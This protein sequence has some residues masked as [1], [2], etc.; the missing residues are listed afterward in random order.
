MM[1]LGRGWRA[2]FYFA[3]IIA[4]P[5]FEVAFA[6]NGHQIAW[7]SEATAMGIVMLIGIFDCWR[8]AWF[9]R[10]DFSARWYSGWPG[11]F[12]VAASVVV[13]YVGLRGF[14]FA[15]YRLPSEA[16]LPGLHVNDLILVRKWQYGLRMPF[17]HTLL[18]KLGSPERGDLVVFRYPLESDQF[19]I[20]R[21]VGLPGDQVLVVDHSL[22]VN[23]KPV[24]RRPKDSFHGHAKNAQFEQFEESLGNASYSVIYADGPSKPVH[25]GLQDTERAACT[26]LDDGVWCSVPAD[27]YFVLGDNRVNSEDSRDWGLVPLG[28]IVGNVRLVLW[29]YQEPDRAWTPV[30]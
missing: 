28:N 19:N 5:E 15:P 24:K 18:A 27:R 29:N 30:Q 4:F 6:A 2:L 25:P 10:G 14:A 13:C 8:I 7:L 23:G 11:I 1:Y 17:V 9:H 20:K 16:M 21:I 26:Y 22:F 3:A 12:G